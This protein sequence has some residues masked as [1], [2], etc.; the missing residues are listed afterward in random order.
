M[1]FREYEMNQLMIKCGQKKVLHYLASTMSSI[2]RIARTHSV[3]SETADIVTNAGCIIF[4]LK[5][6][7]KAPYNSVNVCLI[8][9]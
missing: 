8:P 7:T 3:A 1:L 4:S 5:V 6:S 9:F 2:L